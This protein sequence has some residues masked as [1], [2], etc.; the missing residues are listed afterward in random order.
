[1]YTQTTKPKRKRAAKTKPKQ[2]LKDVPFPLM[3]LPLEIRTMIYKYLLEENS[4]PLTLLTQ[5]QTGQE[6]VRRGFLNKQEKRQGGRQTL[7]KTVHKANDKSITH[8]TPAILRICKTV[9]EEATPILYGQTL[10]FEH[11]VALQKFLSSIGIKNRLSLLRIVLRGW[12]R[13]VF[14]SWQQVLPSVFDRLLSAENL[15]SITM[16]RHTYS[17]KDGDDVYDDPKDWKFHADYLSERI[18]YWAQC[19]DAAKGNGTARSLLIFSDRN[20]DTED[21]LPKRDQAFLDR[22]KVFF[23]KLKLSYK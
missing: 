23:E 5:G 8:L 19:I 9:H 10:E 11:P 17:G 4:A 20:F 3:D 14:P 22:Q 16:D 1:L 18:E 21:D 12:Q 7:L 13:N 15:K 6:V 2:P